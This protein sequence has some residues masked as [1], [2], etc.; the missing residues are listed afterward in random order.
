MKY[1]VLLRGINVGGKNI[2]KMNDLKQ[3]LLDLNFKNIQPYIQSG[4]VILDSD[5]DETSLHNKISDG[6]VKQFGFEIVMI[7]RNIDEIQYLIAQMPF[8]PDE[9]IA[10]E[11]ADPQVEHLYVYFLESPPEESQIEAIRRKYAGSD[12]L[13]VG[14]RECYLLCHQSIRKSKLAGYTSKVFN[15]AT[16][17]NW[18]SVCNLYDMMTGRQPN[19]KKIER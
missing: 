12:T 15:T 5:L 3:L 13:R 4:N 17:R 19:S 14:K 11:T 10:A 7:I 1:V 16:V 2:I 9:M 18:K 8:S 6:F